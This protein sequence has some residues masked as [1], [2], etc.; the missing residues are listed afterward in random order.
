VPL[1]NQYTSREHTI[2]DGGLLSNFPVWLF[3]APPGQERKRPT[4][5]L[6]LV[7]NDASP[8]DPEPDPTLSSEFLSMLKRSET[9]GYFWSVVDTMMA[10]HDRYYIEKT[11]FD[12]TIEIDSKGVGTTEFKL[13][14]KRKEDLYESGVQKA[15]RFLTSIAVATAPT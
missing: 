3:D 8:G 13:S 11:K 9:L 7:E 10:A 5:G 6:R 14:N 12:K 2:V 1:V 15:E 4:F